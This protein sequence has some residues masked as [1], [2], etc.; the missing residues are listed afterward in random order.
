MHSL[1]AVGAL[2]GA[3][4]G[5]RFAEFILRAAFVKEGFVIH[6]V[7][8]GKKVV[9]KAALRRITVTMRTLVDSLPELFQNISHADI[10]KLQDGF[11][12]ARFLRNDCIHYGFEESTPGSVE[13]VLRAMLFLYQRFWP[14]QVR[15]GAL[16]FKWG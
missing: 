14:E 2:A 3:D 1:S 13:A 11:N 8:Q 16:V 6:E 12:A 15:N 4:V 7:K 5:A 9:N 10:Q